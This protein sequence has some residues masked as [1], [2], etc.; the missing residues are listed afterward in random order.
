MAGGAVGSVGRETSQA[1]AGTG[2][3]DRI[4]E[5]SHPQRTTNYAGTAVEVERRHAG[6]A[7]R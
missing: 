5:Y 3:T 6:G 1:T 4:V 2:L 7:G